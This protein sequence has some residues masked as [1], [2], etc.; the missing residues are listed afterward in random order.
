MLPYQSSSSRFSPLRAYDI[1]ICG[2][3]TKVTVLTSS[4]WPVS[5]QSK[6]KGGGYL[7]NSYT[8]ATF[9]HILPGMHLWVRMLMTPLPQ[10]AVS[11]FVILS[12]AREGKECE[13]SAMSR[14][15]CSLTQVLDCRK[16]GQEVKPRRI[17]RSDSLSESV[18]LVVYLQT[19]G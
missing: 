7:P 1:P 9:E 13:K 16:L 6:Q 17:S 5:L 11:M 18:S 2:L 8:A 15:C 3:L 10:H 4:L 14:V 19:H 12:V